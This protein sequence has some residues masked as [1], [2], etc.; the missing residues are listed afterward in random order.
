MEIESK[1]G[2]SK[3]KL[4]LTNRNFITSRTI[5]FYAMHSIEE[6]SVHIHEF[7]VVLSFSGT[8]NNF[9]TA[10][11]KTMLIN[12]FDI[13]K[14]WKDCILNE[15]VDANKKIIIKNSTCEI[16]AEWIF[17]K[18]LE[19]KDHFVNCSLHSVKVFD[20]DVSVEIL[21]EENV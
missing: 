2:H 18:L 7:R 1:E 20:G 15:L 11:G 14:L 6:K 21:S 5:S 9:S 16:I 4:R 8:R 13:D 10:F 12:Y 19:Y 3:K 17:E